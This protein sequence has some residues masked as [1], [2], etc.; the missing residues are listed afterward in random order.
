MFTT[1]QK[2]ALL[3][4]VQEYAV[5]LAGE[6]WF[7]ATVNKRIGEIE[8]MPESP[9]HDGPGAVLYYC[10]GC[11]MFWDLDNH[12]L[13]DHKLHDHCNIIQRVCIDCLRTDGLTKT[14]MDGFP[15]R[16]RIE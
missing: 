15:A 8:G 10:S 13:P 2:Q 16:E 9:I 14:S 5:D 7:I 6:Q 3:D 1:T 4:L 11:D 12:I